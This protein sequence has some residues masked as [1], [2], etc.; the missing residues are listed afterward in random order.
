[1]LNLE[2]SQRSRAFQYRVSIYWHVRPQGLFP[3]FKCSAQVVVQ[4]LKFPNLESGFCGTPS[5]VQ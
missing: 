2:E 1:M 5:T 3:S 4:M